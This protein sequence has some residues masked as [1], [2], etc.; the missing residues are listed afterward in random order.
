MRV[1]K[2]RATVRFMFHNPD[3][4][5]WFRPVEVRFGL[6]WLTVKLTRC[7]VVRTCRADTRAADQPAELER[8]PNGTHLRPLPAS[9]PV[10]LSTE[11]WQCIHA[12]VRAYVGWPA[13]TPEWGIALNP[14]PPYL[15]LSLTCPFRSCPPSTAGAAASPSRWAPTAP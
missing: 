9:L 7:V 14:H 1:H 3:D 11:H 4:V 15:S 12:A 6:W 5:R 2:R 10:L 8:I 13:Q